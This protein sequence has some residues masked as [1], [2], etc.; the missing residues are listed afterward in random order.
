[1]NRALVAA[2]LIVVSFA[3]VDSR[4]Q[5]VPNKSSDESVAAA[6]TKITPDLVKTH[7]SY[8]GDDRLE[9]RGTGTKGYDLA[10][11]YVATTFKS[12]GLEPAGDRGSY[13]QRVPLL[14]TTLDQSKTT[15]T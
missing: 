7:I 11:E 15:L 1:M 14:E 3:C 4:R 5:A 10:A 9:G 13:L 2:I 6:L 12:M 8:L